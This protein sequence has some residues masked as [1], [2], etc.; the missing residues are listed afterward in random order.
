MTR[1]DFYVLQEQALIARYHFCCRLAE[2]AIN[3]GHHIV[4]AVDDAD[5]ATTLSEYLW[6][7]KP[8]SFLPHD[9]QT[10]SDTS[11]IILVWEEVEDQHHDL[12]INLRDTIPDGFSRFERVFEVVVQE[13]SC[14]TST[15]NHF[16]FYRDRGYPLKSHPV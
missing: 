13:E 3:H 16:Q 7:F 14:L 6:S 9:L 1:V 5:Q 15:R 11:P 8:E 4:I 12:L 10:E 2:K